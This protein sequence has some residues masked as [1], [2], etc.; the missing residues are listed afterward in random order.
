M[1]RASGGRPGEEA[2]TRRNWEAW[3]RE[4]EA[5]QAALRVRMH[6]PREQLAE[7]VIQSSYIRERTWYEAERRCA[8]LGPAAVE[9]V[10]GQ[11]LGRLWGESPETQAEAPRLG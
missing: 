6:E 9:E 3:R 7:F 10:S 1:E 4:E 5:F 11:A 2:R 8:R